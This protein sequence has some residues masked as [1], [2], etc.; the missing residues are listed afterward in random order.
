MCL[1]AT[2][3]SKL[4]ALSQTCTENEKFKSADGMFPADVKQGD[5]LPP[6]LRSHIVD[7]CSLFTVLS[8]ALLCL[9]LAIFLLKMT[10]KQ[11]PV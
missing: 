9:F 1:F 6:G 7:R 4:M 5:A 2:P 10:P 11:S 3:K 8:S